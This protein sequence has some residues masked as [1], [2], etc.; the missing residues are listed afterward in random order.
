MTA[1]ECYLWTSGWRLP[2]LATTRGIKGPCHC[3]EDQPA[4]WPFRS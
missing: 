4:S 2:P 3:P 1:A